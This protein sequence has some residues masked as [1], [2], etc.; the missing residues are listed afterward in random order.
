VTSYLFVRN[1]YSIVLFGNLLSVTDFLI[2]F[3]LAGLAADRMWLGLGAFLQQSEFCA[4]LFCWTFCENC[5]V[6]C[7]QSMSL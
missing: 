4:Y 1:L 3:G 2:Y 5:P 6:I 7:N